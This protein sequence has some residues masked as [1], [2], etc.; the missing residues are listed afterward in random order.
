MLESDRQARLHDGQIAHACSVQ[1][2]RRANASHPEGIAVHPSDWMQRRKPS[3]ESLYKSL[4]VKLVALPIEE[5]KDV[6]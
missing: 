2:A 6:A 1:I 5:E 4:S 3:S